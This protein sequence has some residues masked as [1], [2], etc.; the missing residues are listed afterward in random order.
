MA[1][2]AAVGID[3]EI[4]V[5]PLDKTTDVVGRLSGEEKAAGRKHQVAITRKGDIACIIAGVADR[6]DTCLGHHRNRQQLPSAC[7]VAVELEETAERRE[8]READVAGN[9]C[10]SRLPGKAWNCLCFVGDHRQQYQTERNYPHGLPASHGMH[11]NPPFF[12]TRW[13]PQRSPLGNLPSGGSCALNVENLFVAY[14]WSALD[15]LKSCAV[16]QCTRSLTLIY[17]DRVR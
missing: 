1:A 17:K 9:A 7:R 13:F 8:F 15:K 4:V 6:G 11:C 14:L 10:L 12:A 3:I 2:Q 5:S 16:T